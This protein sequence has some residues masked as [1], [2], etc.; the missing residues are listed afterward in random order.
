MTKEYSSVI[1]VGGKDNSQ[2]IIRLMVQR[3]KVVN[4]I[5]ESYP[6]EDTSYATMQSSEIISLLFL[7]GL[8]FTLESVC[9]NLAPPA[10]INTR[11]SFCNYWLDNEK[12]LESKVLTSKKQKYATKIIKTQGRVYFTRK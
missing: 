5:G 12:R 7:C 9:C 8:N 6:L 4:A 10:Q 11:K 2:E 3:D 1:I